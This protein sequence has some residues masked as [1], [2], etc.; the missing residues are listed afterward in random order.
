MTNALYFAIFIATGMQLHRQEK[1][2]KK[3]QAGF[4]TSR[5]TDQIINA[6]D[7]FSVQPAYA[8]AGVSNYLTA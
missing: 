4:D 2:F 7:Y 1:F 8:Y 6:K 5:K 3:L